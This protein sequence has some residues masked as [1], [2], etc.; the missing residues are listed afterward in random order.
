M[1]EDVVMNAT[2]AAL[3]RDALKLGSR[4]DAR[5]RVRVACSRALKAMDNHMAIRDEPTDDVNEDSKPKP[6][7]KKPRK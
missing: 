2:T 4:R 6:K 7:A 5:Q 1:G 3:V